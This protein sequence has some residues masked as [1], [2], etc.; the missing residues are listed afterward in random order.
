LYRRA[1]AIFETTLGKR[2]PNVRITRANYQ[3]LLSAIR[4]PT[5]RI[6]AG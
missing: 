6:K 1:L 2:R 3:K 5:D 4:G